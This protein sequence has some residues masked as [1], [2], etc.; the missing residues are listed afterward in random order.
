MIHLKGLLRARGL[1]PPEGYSGLVLI[2]Q[3]RVFFILLFLNMEANILGQ[4]K[5][6]LM[7]EV[8]IALLALHFEPL[9]AKSTNHLTPAPSG[10]G[11]PSGAGRWWVSVVGPRHMQTLIKCFNRLL[12]NSVF[13]VCGQA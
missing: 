3:K 11:T 8:L 9:G 12:R 4:T 6:Q 2:S 7:V 13:I 1:S 10:T 5:V